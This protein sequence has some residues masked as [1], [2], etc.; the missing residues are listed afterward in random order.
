MI[1]PENDHLPHLWPGIV[2]STGASVR[3]SGPDPSRL[4]CRKNDHLAEGVGIRLNRVTA[5]RGRVGVEGGVA[6]EWKP[7]LAEERRLSA[8]RVDDR[9]LF[10]V[11][12]PSALAVEI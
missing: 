9:D 8:P 3:L 5:R 6:V 1:L 11:G 10:R 4:A 2:V 12:G 7:Q